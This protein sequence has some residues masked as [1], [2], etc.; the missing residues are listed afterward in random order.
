MLKS[1]AKIILRNL[2]R[3][4]GYSVINLFGLA[5]G[6]LVCLLVYMFV[7]FQLGYDKKYNKNI[8]RLC[9]LQ[10][11]N[12]ESD[13]QKNAKSLFP[14]G[15]ALKNEVAGIQDYCRFVM[16][17]KVPLQKADKSGTMAT[18]LGADSQF[19]SFWGFELIEGNRH[20]ALKEPGSIVLTKSLARRM[21]GD[22]NPI[23]MR[24]DHEGRDTQHFTV[25]GILP[26]IV[27]QSHLQFDAVYS[28]STD[29]KPEWNDNWEQSWI[30][31]YLKLDDKTNP[32]T[33]D[34]SLSDFIHRHTKRSSLPGIRL[35]LQPLRNVHLYSGDIHYDAINA[36]KFNGSYLPPLMLVGIF[37]ML[38]AIVNYVNLNTARLFT[39]VKEVGI[40]KAIGATY[41][42]ILLRFI[43]ETTVFALLA[44]ILALLCSLLAM[45]FL[46]ELIGQHLNF[47]VFSIPQWIFI[48]LVAILGTGLAAGIIPAVAIASIDVI[49]ALKGKLSVSYH[50]PLRNILVVAQFSIATGL[51]LS[52]IVILRQLQFMR[53]YNVGFNKQA[54]IVA[55]VS[56]VD[57]QTEETMI[58]NLKQIPGVIDVT[59]ALRRLGST[60]DQNEIVFSGDDH[61]TRL[62]SYNMFVDFNYVSFYNIQLVAG[63]SFSMEFGDDRNG[64]SYIINKTLAKKLLTYNAGYTN[65]TSLVGKGLRYG[66]EDSTGTIIGIVEDFNFG[67]LHQAIEPLC[68]SYQYEYYFPELSL[69]LDLHQLQHTL[70]LVEQKWKHAL[71]GQE[72]SWKFLD[73]HLQTLYKS[74]NQLGNLISVFAIVAVIISVMGLAGVTAFITERRTKEI[75]IRKVLGASVK[76]IL[77]FL[78]KEMTLLVLLSIV[79]ALPVTWWAVDLWLRGFAYRL[80]PGWGMY[81][82]VSCF[83]LLLAVITINLQIIRAARVNPAKSLKED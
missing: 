25:T 31:T 37:V 48:T 19:F 67:S 26:D 76:A 80:D 36:D 79:I 82:I 81:A 52:S 63:R 61:N 66:F 50:S 29:I 24:I 13:A 44:F 74:D 2:W 75:G 6:M 64:R 78:S 3:F 43:C 58:Q 32:S 51:L 59:G 83:I 16:W 33:I 39:R 7:Q 15:P 41:F 22:S 11:E 62:S 45:P 5:L 68:L 38:L 21:F 34:N 71:P 28:A 20:I 9:T 18:I 55:P 49:A 23:G 54:V 77:L 35:F 1:Y 47:A 4:K 40:R 46:E 42:E 73:D 53:N 72:F 70:T 27:T 14:A 60:I 65:I 8:F 69:R 30:F 57:R 56:Y 12:N 17:D 10:A